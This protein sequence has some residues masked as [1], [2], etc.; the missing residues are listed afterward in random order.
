[1]TSEEDQRFLAIDCKAN[2]TFI[3]DTE[4]AQK[5]AQLPSS[6]QPPGDFNTVYP[7][8][9]ASG[10]RAVIAAGNTVVIYDI[11]GGKPIRT[12]T[13]SAAVSAVAFAKS[14]HD[15]ASGSVDGSLLVTR[16][17]QESVTLQPLPGGVDVVAFAPDGRVI[18]AGHQQLR[19]YEAS[20]NNLLASLASPVRTRAFRLSAGG[21]RLIAIPATPAAPV[22]WDLEH[23]KII[24]RL[25]RH[26]GQV[27]S[28][29]FVRQGL[30]IL[31]A[32]SDGV[33]RR[34]DGMTGRLRRVYFDTNHF[35]LD[36]AM[37]PDGATVV[38]AASDG[39]LR[40]WEASSGRMFW[41][42]RAHKSRVAGV[43]FAGSNLVSHGYSGDVARWTLP[44]V[45]SSTEIGEQV[46]SV[47]HCLSVR[48]DRETGGLLP[49]QACGEG[50]IDVPTR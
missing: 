6:S 49:Q 25:D 35:L 2:G 36:A 43:H 32:G 20:G 31:T 30:E 24:A 12:I 8:V 48:F 18:A 3:W 11:P 15:L 33:A 23:R 41:S 37:D 14:G 19:I 4:Q 45:P 39:V 7:M 16:D 10:D 17:D 44:P 50:S 28:A 47:I 13:H 26:G 34:W 29:R 46:E 21:D 27:F 42:L 5:L 22:L 1:V 38:T 9:S 40:F